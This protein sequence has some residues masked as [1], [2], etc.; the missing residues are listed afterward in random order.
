MKEIENINEID[1]V[2]QK[3]GITGLYFS[4]DT[5]NVCKT[6]RPKVHSIVKSYNKDNLNIYYVNLEKLKQATGQFMVF[7]VPVITFFHD[8]KEIQ[9]FG[10][11]VSEKE[12]RGFLDRYIEFI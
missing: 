10:R 11:Y 8:K 12:I 7:T 3:E 6:L 4:T 2:L 5:C 1:D 9:R